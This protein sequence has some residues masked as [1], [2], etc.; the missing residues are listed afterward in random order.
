M[1][2]LGIKKRIK[3]TTPD[4]TR[5]SIDWRLP[6]Y[7][8]LVAL[9]IGVAIEL[10]GSFDLIELFY[11]FVVLP[12]AVLVLLV[13][14]IWRRS[15]AVLATILVYGCTSAMMYRVG[16]D[17]R[18]HS[19]W[20]LGSSSFEAEVLKQTSPARGEL[21]H[22]EW[23]SWGFAFAEN[24]AYLVFDQ[25]NSLDT[26]AKSRASGNFSGLPCEVQQVYRLESQWYAVVFYTD[27]SWA[28]CEQ[29]S[30]KNTLHPPDTV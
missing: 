13:A 15:M 2:F 19:R 14:C 21:K 18:V 10:S 27:E 6:L 23:D 17:V 8:A 25:S 4:P 12:L 26:A 22:I 5:R 24:N 29:P 30:P 20:L 16:Y 7:A 28:S 11:Y 3:T 9:T 1:D